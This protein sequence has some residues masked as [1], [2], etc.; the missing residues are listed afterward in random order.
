MPTAGHRIVEGV[1]VLK[2]L[3]N[4]EIDPIMAELERM[5]TQEGAYAC[6][7]VDGMTVGPPHCKGASKPVSGKGESGN[8]W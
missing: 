5:L 7:V 1:D 4:T 2:K 3:L 6:R 8:T